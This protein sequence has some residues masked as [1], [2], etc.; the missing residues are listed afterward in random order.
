MPPGVRHGW[1]PKT[2]DYLMLAFHFKISP[3]SLVGD[4]VIRE[5]NSSLKSKGYNFKSTES[6]KQKVNDLRDIDENSPLIIHKIEALIMSLIYDCFELAI[7][8]VLLKNDVE[9]IQSNKNE[10]LARQI[11]ELIQDNV[12]L[13]LQLEDIARHFDHSSRHLNRVFSSVTGQSIGKFIL[14]NKLH[15]SAKSLLEDDR[16]IKEIAANYSF[17]EP[18]YFTRMFKKYYGVTPVVYRQQNGSI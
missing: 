11:T 8:D 5:L 1:T 16:D 15:M 7:G 9:D 2:D 3:K 12:K 13:P 4:A 6:I 14:Q 10:D 17:N 18:S